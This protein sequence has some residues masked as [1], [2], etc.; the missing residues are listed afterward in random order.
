MP[1]GFTSILNGPPTPNTERP[2]IVGSDSASTLAEGIGAIAKVI[3]ERRDEKVYSQLEDETSEVLSKV[4]QYQTK[5]RGLLLDLS[6]ADRAKVE[7]VEKQLQSLRNGEDQGRISPAYAIVQIRDKI[8]NASIKYPHLASEFRKLNTLAVEGVSQIVSKSEQMDPDVKAAMDILEESQKSGKS[9]FEYREDQR[10]QYNLDQAKKADE[11]ASLLGERRETSI[12][13]YV[14]AAVS[15]DI[16]NIVSDLVSKFRQGRTVKKDELF[17]I[18]A[19]AASAPA[20][21]DA[22]IMREALE[23]GAKFDSEFRERMKKKVEERLAPLRAMAAAADTQDRTIE[24][25]RLMEEGMRL[26]GSVKFMEELGFFATIAKEPGGFEMIKTLQDF[27]N[28]LSKGNRASLEKIAETDAETRMMLDWYDRGLLPKHIGINMANITKDED[29]IPSGNKAVDKAT[30]A[31]NWSLIT[32]E[33]VPL[34]T[35]VKHIAAAIKHGDGV[36]VGTGLER[37]LSNPN[38]ASV[39]RSTPSLIKEAEATIYKQ[40]AARTA[41]LS[42]EDKALIVFNTQTGKF[43]VDPAW[44]E[45]QATQAAELGAL[46]G[47]PTFSYLA[48]AQVPDTVSAAIKRINQ[49]I[50]QLSTL[51][52]KPKQY[53]DEL[54]GVAENKQIEPPKVKEK[55]KLGGQ[56]EYSR[57]PELDL[58]GSADTSPTAAI[59]ESAFDAVHEE[60]M[61]GWKDG[62]MTPKKA[63]ELMKAAIKKYA[64]PN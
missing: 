41:Q 39:I 30:A 45:R 51:G 1:T 40:T 7:E 64:E 17:K 33:R 11:A 9:P 27:S 60:I 2:D 19:L 59:A 53:V 23:S 16:N 8:K 37:L 10:L 38:I 55:A 61:K 47:D 15:V 22:I 63:N 32:S 58:R 42:D 46:G 4:E 6:V 48:T 57:N 49:G 35:R 50:E 29:P 5:K 14:D 43:Q 56:P 36:L 3:G 12:E 34:D 21:I 31:A 25:L 28:K 26:K 18:E 20:E 13:A 24:A 52:L 54:I 44:Q 62:T